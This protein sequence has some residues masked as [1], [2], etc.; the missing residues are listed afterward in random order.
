MLQH[1]NQ[2]ILYHLRS[3]I[4]IRTSVFDSCYFYTFLHIIT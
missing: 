3:A 1:S 2:K 4:A